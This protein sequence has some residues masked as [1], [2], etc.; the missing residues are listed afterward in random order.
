MRRK[1]SELTIGYL[2]LIIV[3]RLESA[4]LRLIRSSVNIQSSIVNRSRAGYW[5][6]LCFSLPAALT[7]GCSNTPLGASQEVFTQQELSWPYDHIALQESLT[8]DALPTLQRFNSN[9]GPLL[10]GVEAFSQAE[11]IAASV[12]Q[13]KNGREM[14][15]S[16]VTF[17]E[18]KLDVTRKYFFCVDE[19]AARFPARVRQGFRFEC[20]MVL[21]EKV[22]TQK[23]ASDH[24]ARVTILGYI[25]D[26][27]RNDIGRFDGATGSPQGEKTLSICGMLLNQTIEAIRLKIESSPALSSKLGESTGVDFEHVNFGPGKVVMVSQDNMIAL[28]IRFGVFAE[29]KANPS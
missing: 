18:Y 17:D 10:G 13:G 9:R 12:G 8:I 24:A 14:W 1:Y 22:L 4:C 26:N 29:T 28:R 16:M 5:C 19:N 3:S 2:L 27:L 20:E 21:D 15:F 11:N 23:Y 6:L 7:G 25:R